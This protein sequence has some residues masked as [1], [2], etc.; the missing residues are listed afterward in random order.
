MKK[1]AADDV[2][3]HFE[4]GLGKR[5]LGLDSAMGTVCPVKGYFSSTG[6]TRSPCSVPRRKNNIDRGV[7]LRVLLDS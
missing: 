5:R 1:L 4:P 6:V 7:R 3:D 2:H